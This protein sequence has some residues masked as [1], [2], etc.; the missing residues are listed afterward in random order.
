VQLCAQA[1]CLEEML[2]ISI[3]RA[4]LFYG[5]PRRRTVVDLDSALRDRTRE[6]AARLHALIRSGKSPP[7]ELA[8]KCKHCS[9]RPVCMPELT[10]RS[11]S[12]R[13]YLERSLAAPG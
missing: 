1:L 6:A 11:A 9:L 5:K 7:A 10:A 12:V 13:D 2:G 8:P 4:D 3:D